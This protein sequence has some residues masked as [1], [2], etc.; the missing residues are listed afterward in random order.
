M[1]DTPTPPHPR[2][3]GITPGEIA[4]SL[5][6]LKEALEVAK[7]YIVRYGHMNDS[8]PAAIR[9]IDNAREVVLVHLP[10]AEEA[11]HGLLREAREALALIL[12]LARGYAA[13][14]RVGSNDHYVRLAE[15]TLSRIVAVLEAR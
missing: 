3:P 15:K 10:R 9:K 4:G 8:C 2:A 12:P 7:I 11:M 1:T 6:T 5:E 13:A 14:H